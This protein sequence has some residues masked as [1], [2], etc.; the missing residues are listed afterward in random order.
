M[1]DSLRTNV[2]VCYRPETIA[3]ACIFLAARELEISLPENPG[4]WLVFDASYEELE[5]IALS[6]LE[7]AGR[8]KKTLEEVE[9]EV[10][11][12]KESKAE[13][14]KGSGDTK[15]V[16]RSSSL[17]ASRDASPKVPTEAKERDNE[18]TASGSEDD[19]SRK[20]H[21][22]LPSRTASAQ[23]PSPL[24]LSSQGAGKSVGATTAV[25]AIDLAGSGGG[26]RSDRSTSDTGSSVSSVEERETAQSRYKPVYSPIRVSP[27][28]K[29]NL[30]L[31]SR[32]YNGR[33]YSHRVQMSS[34]HRRRHRDRSKRSRSRS[35]SRSPDRSKRH[36]HS[37]RYHHSHRHRDI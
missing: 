32:S 22:G 20:L 24:V 28:L 31:D 13:D 1:N 4:W 15:E 29:D 9:K 11:R 27:T 36:H 30:H 6:V 33:S 8:A 37:R 2:F 14:Q 34:R 12:I 18:E 25:Q 35:R 21:L 3:C 26:D 23:V 16:I 17:P 10:A 5:D 19:A 7:M